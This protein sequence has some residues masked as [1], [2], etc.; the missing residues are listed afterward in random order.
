[1]Q[2]GNLREMVHQQD[3]QRN[4]E[5]GQDRGHQA[6]QIGDQSHNEFRNP[7]PC[8]QEEACK[9]GCINRFIIAAPEHFLQGE[10]AGKHSIQDAPDHEA[11]YKRCS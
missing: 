4:R 10:L 5:C 11:E 8:Q 2:P 1:M 3:Q 9:E 6:G 7:D